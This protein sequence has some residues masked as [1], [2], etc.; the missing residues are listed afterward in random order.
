[1]KKSMKTGVSLIIGIYVI[2][3][4]YIVTGCEKQS[5]NT[6]IS[7]PIQITLNAPEQ[8]LAE[9]G[10]SFSFSLLSSVI[11]S[12][13]TDKNI[14]ISPF[15][16]NSCLAMV[17]NAAAGPSKDSVKKAMGYDDFTVSEVNS[18]FK[19]VREAVLKTDNTTQVIIAN[20]I[21]YRQE[22]T[23][24]LP[25]VNINKSFFN[26]EI[27]PIDFSN[28]GNVNL[29]NDWC[30]DKTNGLINEAIDKIKPEDFMYL[31]NALYFKAIWQKG[32]EFD[33]KNTVSTNFNLG[34]GGVAQ[35]NMMKAELKLPYYS[36]QN[37]SMISMPYG[38]G[39][40]SML[41]FLPAPTKD[42]LQ[43]V[44][45]LSDEEY[46]N[47]VIGGAYEKNQ[48]QTVRVEIP[49]FKFRFNKSLNDILKERGMAIVY[50]PFRADFTDAFR[51]VPLIVSD[52][53]QLNYINV[54]EEGTEAAAVTVVTFG[55][56][57]VPQFTEFRLDR[58]FLFAIRENTSGVILFA[59]RVGN[60]AL[61]G[62]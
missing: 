47:S 34:S 59:G 37:L 15:S 29:I 23:P 48:Q 14:S 8:L 11:S 27:N 56:N 62:D 35:V 51:G 2:A 46:L 57:S 25:F 30:S 36:D 10:K 28:Q 38:N 1:M 26:A 19:K 7:E 20:S 49:K 54:D 33:K 32:Y 18:Y 44:V 16:L 9:K 42:P 50:D 12:E 52:V 3:G 45:L 24:E 22:A 58:P 5:D 53:K 41:F 61:E 13:E 55:V 43:T 17:L 21:W 6:E 40:F 4:L 60:P 31:I 39:A